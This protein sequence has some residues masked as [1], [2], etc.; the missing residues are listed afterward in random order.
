MSEKREAGGQ[1]KD[2]MSASLYPSPNFSNGMGLIH[3]GTWNDV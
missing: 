2:F 3:G 1:E